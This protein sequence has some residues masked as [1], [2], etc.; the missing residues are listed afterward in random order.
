MKT[1]EE[2]NKEARERYFRNRD[3]NQTGVECRDCKGTELL[4]ENPGWVCDSIPPSIQVKC[5]KCG[6]IEHIL[7]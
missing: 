2:N 1:I 4:L 5:P 7:M 6:R 3:C